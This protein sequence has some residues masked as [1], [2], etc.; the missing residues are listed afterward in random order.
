MPSSSAVAMQ[1]T[2]ED[3]S[4]IIKD[5]SEEVKGLKE[6]V[7]RMEGQIPKP[8]PK[9]PKADGEVKPK[10][11]EDVQE[12]DGF[13][14]PKV[15]LPNL[16]LDGDLIVIPGRC[17][18]IQCNHQLF[19]QCL[20]PQNDGEDYCTKCQKGGLKYGTIDKRDDP[21]W[22]DTSGKTKRKPK[23][24]ANLW[25]TLNITY[26]QAEKAKDDF[27]QQFGDE[28]A[29]AEFH[30]DDLQA[31]GRGRPSTKSSTSSTESSPVKKQPPKKKGAPKKSPPTVIVDDTDDE[32][33]KPKKIVV[34]K[35]PP[36]TK[37]LFGDDSD[38]EEEKPKKT[39]VKKKPPT[40]KEL[41]GDD[42]D[43]DDDEDGGEVIQAINKAEEELATLEEIIEPKEE[44]QVFE[45]EDVC[46][47]PESSSSEEEEV[48][49]D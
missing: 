10:V 33:E 20:E 40:T 38:E 7:E 15:V 45:E 26:E 34:K 13:I 14:K 31:R 4:Q 49:E 30:Q 46:S 44:L 12:E 47:E 5:L 32:Q 48:D 3:F 21:E 27:L 17:Q 39:V 16:Y 1:K 28:F 2:I 41:F 19:T 9:K 8:K 29:G 37:E 42:T 43:D 35:K 25:K 24:A 6:T 18:A 23:P 11:K 22:V 36:T